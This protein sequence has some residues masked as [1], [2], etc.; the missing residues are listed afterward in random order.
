MELL[1]GRGIADEDEFYFKVLEADRSGMV[2]GPVISN[3]FDS[4]EV[5]H[6]YFYFLTYKCAFS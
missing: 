4:Y 5:L 1:V 3:G 6:S 2:G